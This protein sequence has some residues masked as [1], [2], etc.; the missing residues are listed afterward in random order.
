MARS[1]YAYM[2]HQCNLWRCPLCLF[3][4]GP[5]VNSHRKS[6]NTVLSYMYEQMEISKLSFPA[7]LKINST[8]KIRRILLFV[9]ST[10]PP[11]CTVLCNSKK[12]FIRAVTNSTGHRVIKDRTVRS[13]QQLKVVLEGAGTGKYRDKPS[14]TAATTTARAETEQ[15]LL[16][17]LPTEHLRRRKMFSI[18]L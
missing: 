2:W 7:D 14:C 13:N 16:L 6:L 1:G 12:C 17:C 3:P 18:K 15:H 5:H 10:L 8:V 4:F 11:P 9:S